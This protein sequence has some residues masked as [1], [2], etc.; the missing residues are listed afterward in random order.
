MSKK[1]KKSIHKDIL[2]RDIEIGDLVVAAD[3]GRRGSMSFLRVIAWGKKMV[4][5]ADFD[6]QGTE[7]AGIGTLRYP[8]DVMKLSEEQT[9]LLTLT[10][11]KVNNGLFE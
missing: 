4:R 2:G 1:A 10:N 8:K 6:Y 11:G 9:L 5:V 3:G 7:T